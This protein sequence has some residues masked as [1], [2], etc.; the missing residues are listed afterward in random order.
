MS[1]GCYQKYQDGIEV[2]LSDLQDLEIPVPNVK[3]QRPRRL[4]G[5]LA[6]PI[7][8]PLFLLGWTLFIIGGKPPRKH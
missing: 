8:I 2:G 4:Y 6:W 1:G 3:P 5:Y 7:V